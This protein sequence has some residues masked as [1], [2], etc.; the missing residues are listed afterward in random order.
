L[1]QTDKEKIQLTPVYWWVQSAEGF[2]G[3]RQNTWPLFEHEMFSS[4]FKTEGK[5]SGEVHPDIT[6]TITKSLP[7]FDWADRCGKPEPVQ[8]LM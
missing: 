1:F 2:T 5:N 8:G 7:S 3:C 4:S 6:F